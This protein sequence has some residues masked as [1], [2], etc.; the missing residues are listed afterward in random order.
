[1][2]VLLPPVCAQ[3]CP[4][5]LSSGY[6]PFRT[7][8]PEGLV[9]SRVLLANRGLCSAD[10][11]AMAD[12]NARL[13]NSF[14]KQAWQMQSCSTGEGGAKS[15]GKGTW[16]GNEHTNELHGAKS[17]CKQGERVPLASFFLTGSRGT[18]C[19]FQKS[20]FSVPGAG[21][22]SWQAQCAQ[23]NCLSA[24]RRRGAE[25]K[26]PWGVEVL[27]WGLCRGGGWTAGLPPGTK[28][29]CLSRRHLHTSLPPARA[30]G[31]PQGLSRQE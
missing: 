14:G 31:I 22:R 4:R 8:Y 5:H 3:T 25:A 23:D 19:A 9:S 2:F 30:P 28:D 12:D 7:P 10:R 26:C 17:A 24:G 16:K 15:R 18:A 11:P 20:H 13:Q 29:S 1:M 6:Q 27:T 21:G